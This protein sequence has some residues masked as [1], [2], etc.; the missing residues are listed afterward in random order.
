MAHRSV[1]RHKKI[2]IGLIV[3]VVV[4]VG[5]GVALVVVQN[6][7]VTQNDRYA[8]TLPRDA[9][10][11]NED[12]SIYATL[13][14]QYGTIEVAIVSGARSG[15]SATQRGNVTKEQVRVDG[16]DAEQTKID[17]SSSTNTNTSQVRREVVISNIEQHATK[18]RIT[19]IAT[20]ELTTN[21]ARA[22]YNDAR[23]I[24]NTIEIR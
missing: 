11:R 21:E 5:I 18:V 2:I 1:G 16:I 15:V 22:F 10:I 6:R 9:T 7:S 13:D 20:R 24:I 23:R 8:V 17:Y 3:G 19:A 12:N 4:C 14:K